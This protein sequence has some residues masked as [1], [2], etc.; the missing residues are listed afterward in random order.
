MSRSGRMQPVQQLAESRERDAGRALADARA[1]LADQEQQLEQL[2][3]YR[4]EYLAGG[5]PGLGTTD[6]VRLSNRSAFLER[7]NDA[8]RE[9]RA[10]VDRAQEESDRYAAAWQETRVEAAAIGRA[11]DRFRQDERRAVERVEQREHD[12]FAIR[13]PAKPPG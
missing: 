3:R 7:L 5:S 13:R 11:V 6:T 2:L 9:Q 10:R 1:R 12:E 4:D 8:I